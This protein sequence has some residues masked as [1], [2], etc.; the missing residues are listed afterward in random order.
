MD[1][2]AACVVITAP[3][4]CMFS[5]LSMLSVNDVCKGDEAETTDVGVV[6][7]SVV[8]GAV[9]T[10]GFGAMEAIIF[11]KRC[12]RCVKRC[13]CRDGR[14]LMHRMGHYLYRVRVQFFICNSRR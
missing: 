10:N 2:I 12:Y 5:V 1:G 3:R 13:A 11:M 14:R 7:C 9:I 4:F 6:E 8:R